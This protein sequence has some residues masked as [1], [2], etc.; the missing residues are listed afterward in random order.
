M[1]LAVSTPQSISLAG[2]GADTTHEQRAPRLDIL[3]QVVTCRVWRMRALDLRVS[4]NFSV[5]NG[6]LWLD[7]LL[8]NS[9]CKMSH[10]F[11]PRV[12]LGVPPFQWLQWQET[13]KIQGFQGWLLEKLSIHRRIRL[14]SW[15]CGSPPISMS[16]MENWVL[17]FLLY[18]KFYI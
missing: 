14:F 2:N 18:T 1:Q 11:W 15:I 9:A 3:A 8:S 10:L 6:K 13:R 12:D 17:D 16:L 7:F 4:A 5:C